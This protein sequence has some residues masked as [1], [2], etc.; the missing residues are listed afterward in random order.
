MGYFTLKESLK[1]KSPIVDINHYLN[2]VLP[3]FDSL[4]KELFLGFHLIDIFSDCFFFNIIKYKDA[5]AKAVHF[6]KLE[7]VYQDFF[8]NFN[9]V[10]IISDTSIKNNIVISVSHI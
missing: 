9:T 3:A 4:N 7:N 6:N 5:E 2:S 1:V 10:F 8:N